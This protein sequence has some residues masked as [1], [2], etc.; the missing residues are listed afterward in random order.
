MKAWYQALFTDAHAVFDATPNG[1]MKSIPHVQRLCFL[2]IRSE[3]PFTQT[4]GIFE[5]PDAVAAGRM[6]QGLDHMQFREATLD[7]L[8]RRYEHLKACQIEPTH[9]YNHGTATSFYYADPDGNVAELTAANF[10]AEADYLAFFQSEAFKANVEG[11]PI[12]AP[13][14]IA[15]YRRTGLLK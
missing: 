15:H 8:F 11:H 13:D 6:T 4:V 1:Q 9:A 3:Y 7:G 10:L 14:C 12:D 2:R 5:A